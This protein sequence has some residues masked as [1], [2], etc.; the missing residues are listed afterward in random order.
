MPSS[1][2]VALVQ[3][4][5]S[6]SHA[7]N[8]GAVLAMMRQ[9]AGKGAEFIGLPEYVSGF[10]ADANG[11]LE[12]PTFI[13]AEHPALQAFAAE[14]KRLGVVVHVGSLAIRAPDGRI[15]NRGFVLDRKGAI[16]ARYDKIHLFDVDLG[17]GKVYRE[18]KIVAPGNAAVVA[19]TPWGGLGMSICYDLR[20][21]A[22]YRALAQDG[23]ELLSVPA[24][25]TKTTGLVHWHVLNRARAIETGSFVLA[26][27]QFGR[28]SGGSEAYGHSLIIDPWGKVL[29]DG[30]E[31]PALVMA[32]LNLADVASARGRIPSLQHDRPFQRPARPAKAAE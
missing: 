24:A 11:D 18:S 6:A 32:T 31:G 30:G 19:P 17:P 28:F 8:I 22:L 25:F 2:S 13:E 4:N 9:A 26:A 16:S 1:V 15:A 12:L 3:N 14:A 5:A 10:G 7:D 29:A 23:A 27:C 20:F 21:A